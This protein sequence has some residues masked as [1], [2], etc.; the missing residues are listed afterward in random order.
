MGSAEDLDPQRRSLCMP[1]RATSST[2]S[3]Q[4][5]PGVGAIECFTQFGDERWFCGS[6]SSSCMAGLQG[7]Q[8]LGAGPP[9]WWTISNSNNMDREPQKSACP[10]PLPLPGPS[11]KSRERP[12]SKEQA[13]PRKEGP[14]CTSC[15]CW[16]GCQSVT[17]RL[18]RAGD[19]VG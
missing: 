5:V 2:F 3:T 4:R 8:E 16:K 6:N 7:S 11:Q 19:Q 14:R 1:T 9:G 17:W 18:R 15:L 12:M 13:T 10:W